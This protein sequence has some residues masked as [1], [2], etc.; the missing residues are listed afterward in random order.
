ME[1]SKTKQTTQFRKIRVRFGK[2]CLLTHEHG[3]VAYQ[4]RLFFGVDFKF[5]IKNI[6]GSFWAGGGY[7]F[8][9]FNP[10]LS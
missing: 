3:S 4:F 1:A 7:E 8:S 6:V 2:K 9:I 10:F 5:D